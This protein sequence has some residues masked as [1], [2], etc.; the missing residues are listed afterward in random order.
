MLCYYP[1]SISIP[2]T[3]LSL[4]SFHSWPPVSHCLFFSF[5][6]FP[7]HH[8][9]TTLNLPFFPPLFFL[10][11]LLCLSIKYFYSSLPRKLATTGHILV[12]LICYNNSNNRLWDGI[13]LLGPW[14]PRVIHLEHD[15]HK[16]RISREL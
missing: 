1:L 6:V 12:G 7:I 10:P 8:S 13:T 15:L 3:P 11:S 5:F 9:S 16:G 14:G 4:F 2:V